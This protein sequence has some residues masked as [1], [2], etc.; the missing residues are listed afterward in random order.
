MRAM[1]EHQLETRGYISLECSDH[2]FSR[3]NNN[4]QKKDSQ[5]P[6]VE[7]TRSNKWSWPFHVTQVVRE[8]AE[9][10]I[11]YCSKNSSKSLFSRFAGFCRFPWR[12]KYYRGGI[13]LS[14]AILRWRCCHLSFISRFFINV[15]LIYFVIL[16]LL[17][18]PPLTLGVFVKCLHSGGFRFL[19]KRVFF[20][21]GSRHVI[22]IYSFVSFFACW[23][24]G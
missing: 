22:I 18:L 19:L 9:I 15:V 6:G 4:E 14:W 16:Q 13:S 7:L 8:P 24:L 3:E 11:C 5:Q 20:L 10:N 1:D 2:V 12:R 17:D 21:T 23:M